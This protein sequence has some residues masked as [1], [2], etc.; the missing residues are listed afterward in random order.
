MSLARPSLPTTSL[1]RGAGAPGTDNSNLVVFSTSG[2]GSEDTRSGGGGSDSRE[3]GKAAFTIN[4]LCKCGRRT[5]PRAREPDEAG[6]GNLARGA[7]MHHSS[8]H[9]GPQEKEKPETERR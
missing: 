5:T 4:Q 7:Q 3:H 9:G 1:P 8:G 6:V 2:A